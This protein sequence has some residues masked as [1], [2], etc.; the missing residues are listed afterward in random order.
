MYSEHTHFTCIKTKYAIMVSTQPFI[1]IFIQM[2]DKQV[3]LLVLSTKRIV[4]T[5]FIQFFA[6]GNGGSNGGMVFV[7]LKGV[8]F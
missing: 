1:Q 8:C 6:P 3:Q 5:S 4:I 2:L 7:C